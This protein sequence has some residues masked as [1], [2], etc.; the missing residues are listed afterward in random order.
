MVDFV[1][2]A[3][4]DEA[5]DEEV[6]QRVVGHEHE[7]S[8]RVRCQPRVVLPD[9]QLQENQGVIIPIAKN[10]CP[11]ANFLFDASY[12]MSNGKIVYKFRCFIFL[13]PLF[14]LKW[15]M[16]LRFS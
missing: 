9:E 14:R 6:E 13:L 16:I 7:K 4:E 5:A 3:D 10:S 8:L 1:R 15:R 11:T 12:A 2:D